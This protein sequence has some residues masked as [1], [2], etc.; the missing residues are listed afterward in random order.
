M[1]LTTS[2]RQRVRPSD[3]ERAE[4]NPEA[5]RIPAPKTV[6]PKSGASAWTSE[7]TIPKPSGSTRIRNSPVSLSRM[8]KALFGT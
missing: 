6:A 4:I 3:G 7:E 2:W 1:W 8:L 5:P